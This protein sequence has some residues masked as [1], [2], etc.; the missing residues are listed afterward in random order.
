MGLGF[1]KEMKNIDIVVW[2]ATEK[3]TSSKAVDMYANDWGVPSEDSKN[4]FTTTKTESDYFIDFESVRALKPKPASKTVYELKIGKQMD[5]M[6][7]YGKFEGGVMKYPDAFDNWSMWIRSDGSVLSLESNSVQRKEVVSTKDRYFTQLPPSVVT[8]L[9]VD[10]F[11]VQNKLRTN[12]K[13]FIPWIEEEIG[14]MDG[15]AILQ[16][17]GVWRTTSE[18]RGSY[19]EAIKAL[20]EQGEMEPFSWN[21]GLFLAARD[22][23][24]DHRNMGIKTG[25]TGSDGSTMSSRLKRY[26]HVIGE[27]SENISY[28]SKT[29]TD[30]VM[31]LFID[32][33]VE[34]R[35]NRINMQG[36]YDQVGIHA[37]KGHKEVDDVTV[38][39][40]AVSFDKNEKALQTVVFL[41][42]RN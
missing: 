28:G 41:N 2:K 5:F 25:H 7:S 19:E 6:W 29:A 22:H 32:D 3:A 30:I 35:V 24:L 14:R 37:C 17:D 20:K 39:D 33:G 11:N 4:H 15:I 40:Y 31:Q 9:D 12:P 38:M 18:G 21:D 34:S 16:E 42:R 36:A 13:S 10:I 8:D 26:G 23:C 27:A 1:G